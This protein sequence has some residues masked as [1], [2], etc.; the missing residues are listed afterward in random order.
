MKSRFQR[1]GNKT[2]MLACIDP[3]HA[4]V[5]SGD[6]TSRLQCVRDLHLEPYVLGVAPDDEQLTAAEVISE[7][8]QRVI[9]FFLAFAAGT[10]KEGELNPRTDE[11]LTRRQ[12]PYG[13]KVGTNTYYF[14]NVSPAWLAITAASVYPFLVA[15]KKEWDDLKQ[16]SIAYPVTSLWPFKVLKRFT[17]FNKTFADRL[18]RAFRSYE[19]AGGKY[20]D[21]SDEKAGEVEENDIM[22]DSNSCDDVF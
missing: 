13:K 9:E 8:H 10:V 7:C 20:Y 12:K 11:P 17:Y 22:E 18:Q 21:E 5:R 14:R 19:A 1:W 6:V 2:A 3:W 4:W 16:K 15:E